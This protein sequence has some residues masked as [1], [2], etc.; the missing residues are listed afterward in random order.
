MEKNKKKTQNFAKC[1]NALT[2]GQIRRRSPAMT[3][4]IAE[5]IEG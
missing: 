3:R 1:L 2:Y 4:E 5:Q